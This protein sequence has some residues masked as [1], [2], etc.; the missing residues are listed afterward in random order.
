[1]LSFKREQSNRLS[2]AS[3]LSFSLHCLL[4]MNF[5]SSSQSVEHATYTF[6]QIWKDQFL[7][8]NCSQVNLRKYISLQ[9]QESF[10]FKYRRVKNSFLDLASNTVYQPKESTISFSS[11]GHQKQNTKHLKYVSLS[12]P[13]RQSLTL[14]GWEFI[15]TSKMCEMISR[16]SCVGP[17]KGYF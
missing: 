13:T 1:M 3:N 15:L 10:I 12:S 16:E 11:A 6:T 7:V 17:T 4:S 14:P 9:S 2:K 8:K 5:F